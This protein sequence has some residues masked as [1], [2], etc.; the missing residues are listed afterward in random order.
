MDDPAPMQRGD[1]FETFS[2][3]GHCHAW[4]KTTVDFAGRDDSFC[5]ISPASFGHGVL[6]KC[7]SISSENMQQVKSID[8]L[9]LQ[10][11][12]PTVELK[13]MDRNKV[14]DLNASDDRGDFG[15][16]MHLLFVS[17]QRTERGG[18][19]EFQGNRNAK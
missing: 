17:Q 5:N 12:N 8:P 15:E 19:E 9:H 3:D 6:N 10:Y 4:F 2:N 16:A 11:I 1:S 14:V 7:Q 13:C 18:R